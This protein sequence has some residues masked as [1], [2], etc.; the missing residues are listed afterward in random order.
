M[1]FI[2][3]K[4]H[5]FV[6]ISIFTCH[7][8]VA[9]SSTLATSDA[10]FTELSVSDFF[11][12]F[13]DNIEQK[14]MITHW[15]KEEIL[16]KI[17]DD[18]RSKLPAITQ[19]LNLI[20]SL[21]FLEIEKQKL[22]Q[23][24]IQNL[25]NVNSVLTLFSQIQYSQPNEQ[26][27]APELLSFTEYINQDNCESQSI[28][29]TWPIPLFPEK[30]PG[31]GR[32]HF[33]DLKLSDCHV[34]QGVRFS[35][36]LNF[37]AKGNTKVFL[38]GNLY[39]SIPDLAQALIDNGHT[40]KIK[41]FRTYAD[42][43]ALTYI[44]DGKNYLIRWPLWL[45][46]GVPLSRNKNLFTPTGH[47]QHNIEVSGPILKT[48]ISFF[49]GTDGAGFFPINTVRPKWTGSKTTY[50][51]SSSSKKNKSKVF[52]ALELAE[53]YLRFTWKEVE[54]SARGLP[55]Q[56]YG[57]IGVCNDSTAL[58]EWV[59]HPKKKNYVSTWPLARSQDFK[60]YTPQFNMNSSDIKILDLLN[61]IPKDIGKKTKL[62][63][64]TLHRILEMTP[65]SLENSKSEAWDWDIELREGLLE[66]K[67]KVDQLE[68]KLDTEL[69]LKL[70]LSP[71][72]VTRHPV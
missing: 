9:Y 50:I 32:G 56:G 10:S 63:Y 33:P 31:L 61:E 38:N 13:D 67:E 6:I 8:N 72:I 1:Y 71:W 34:A 23:I 59:I 64:M 28:Q 52:Q 55:A 17:G 24:S 57:Y 16:L 35:E 5:V 18:D 65:I 25:K 58:L 44:K 54:T 20:D 40:I 49:L 66:L 7:F 37:I 14:K 36:I 41:N 42:F 30:I 22:P 19:L 11:Q 39:D 46:T 69:M 27:P 21:D 51:L 62:D 60:N 15:L 45:D 70:F 48:E 26:K 53:S 12:L 47:S 43:V 3:K 2:L 4:F 68:P 29:R